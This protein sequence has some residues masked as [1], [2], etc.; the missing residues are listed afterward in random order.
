VKFQIFG[1]LRALEGKCRHRVCPFKPETAIR[2][3]RP[4]PTLCGTKCTKWHTIK[5]PITTYTFE[6]PSGR[7]QRKNTIQNGPTRNEQDKNQEKDRSSQRGMHPHQGNRETTGEKCR[8]FR[9]RGD[10]GPMHRFR[11]HT[12][13]GKK[14]N[15]GS[16]KKETNAPHPEPALTGRQIKRH[17]AEGL[18][19]AEATDH[20][21]LIT[22]AWDTERLPPSR[23]LPRK[24]E[25]VRT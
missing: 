13:A 12:D 10:T 6:C 9:G 23:N 16:R 22:R 7:Q 8:W 4:P 2:L 20:R 25:I 1:R 18:L 11:N 3:T 19:P 5:P 15:R 24:V 17:L 21:E 14:K